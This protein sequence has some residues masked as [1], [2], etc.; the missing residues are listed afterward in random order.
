VWLGIERALGRHVGVQLSGHYGQA[1]LSGL[2]GQYTL[3]MTY[4]SRPPPFYEPVEVEVKR[5]EAQPAAEGRL[6]TVAVS[7]D[8]VGWADAGS[9]GRVGLTAGPAWL[10][11]KGSAQSLVYTAY[12]MGGHS[13]AFPGDYRVSFEFP[14]SALGLDL[15]GFAEVD[16]GRHAGLRLDARYCWAPEKDAEVSVSEVLNPEDITRTLAEVDIQAGL[17]PA[18]VR[19]DLSFFRAAIAL[20]I[21]F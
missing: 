3:A 10:H 4:T 8:V 19:L 13:V 6:K 9:R 15:G 20:S 1:D 18:P 17:A 7:L 16:L 14:A 11:A 5:A 2:P 12:F 21:R